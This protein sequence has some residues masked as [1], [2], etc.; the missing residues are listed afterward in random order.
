[1]QE[2]KKKKYIILIISIILFVI[3][4]LG[5]Y[6]Y[7]NV[8]EVDTIYK[9][10]KVDRY[11]IS[12][13]TKTEALNFVKD[14]KEEEIRKKNMKLIYLEDEYIVPLTDIGIEYNFKNAITKAY[15][16]GREGN[17]FKRIYNILNIRKNGINILLEADFNEKSIK[18]II[19]NIVEDIDTD[20][21]DAEFHFNDGDIEI[22]DEVVGKTVD[23]EKLYNEIKDNLCTLNDIEIPVNS[24]M[25]KLSKDLL[26]RINGIIGEFSTSFKGSSKNRI[27]NIGLSANA[28]KGKMLMPGE[29][30]SFNET[31]GPRQKEFGYKESSVIMSGEFSSGVGGGVC[32]TSTTLYNVLLLSDITIIER[33]HH[34]IP[35][36]YVNLGQDAAV[37]TGL[38]DLKFKNDFDYPI[39]FDS[40]ITEDRLYFYV[41]GDAEKRDYTVKIESETVETV[42]PEEEITVDKSLEPGSRVL[43]QQGRTG[44]KVNTY[45]YIVKDGKAIDRELITQDY[46]KPRNS[47]YKV[48]EEFE[49]TVDINY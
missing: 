39:Y 37:A 6:V 30:M 23:K 8:L 13:M 15:S 5:L 24:I 29:T 32:Q 42:H 19:E 18:N 26:S 28:I 2:I 9:G 1:M 16:A 33:T 25:P 47:I 17:V 46:Y 45:K 38:L 3:L 22:V 10:V 21:K 27:D 35:I 43:V 11:D 34:S 44:Y 49:K 41:Y 40:K 36:G 12:L 4:G 14:K 20:A 7:F 48:G 31:T